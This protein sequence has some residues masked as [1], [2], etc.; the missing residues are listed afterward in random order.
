MNTDKPIPNQV[1][2]YSEGS[3]HGDTYYKFENDKWWIKGRPIAE[4]KKGWLISLLTPDWFSRALSGGR[5]VP[6]PSPVEKSLSSEP[7][8]HKPVGHITELDRIGIARFNIPTPPE[9]LQPPQPKPK[10]NIGLLILAP[11]TCTGGKPWRS[12]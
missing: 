11:L 2:R 10:S 12:V 4:E 6:V 9:V 8:D 5:L 7:V 3:T 1:Y